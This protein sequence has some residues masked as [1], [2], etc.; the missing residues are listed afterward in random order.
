MYNFKKAGIFCLFSL[1]LPSH[2]LFAQR[3]DDSWC[4]IRCI[5][6]G[7]RYCGI[8]P[9]PGRTNRLF[10]NHPD[11]ISMYQLSRSLEREGLSVK[12]VKIGVPELKELDM[13]AI[14][15]FHPYY[16]RPGAR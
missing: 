1:L 10:R 3:A 8:T 15:Y 16:G 12:G 7:C 5:L 4:G 6:A 13:F 14:G 2:N 9:D 11:G